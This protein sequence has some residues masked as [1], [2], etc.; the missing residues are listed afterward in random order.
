MIDDRD[1]F[2]DPVIGYMSIRLED[3]LAFKQENLDW[4]KLSNCQSGKLRVSAEWKPLS[5]AGSLHG[6]DQYR[7]PIGVIRLFLEK[8]TDV[9]NV[10]AAL[11]GKVR[12]AIMSVGRRA[13]AQIERSIYSCACEQCHPWKDR[14]CEQQ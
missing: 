13:N 14:S 10:E 5:L 7:P 8:A 2:K 6:A 9:K 11:G 4:F 1:F 12:R 3:L